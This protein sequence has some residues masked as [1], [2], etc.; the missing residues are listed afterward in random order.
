MLDELGSTVRRHFGVGLI[1]HQNNRGDAAGSDAAYDLEGEFSVLGRLSFGG[2]AQVPLY[3]FGDLASSLDMAGRTAADRDNVLAPRFEVE[4]RVESNNSVEAAGGDVQ[5]AGKVRD[6]FFRNIPK[7]VL[8]L[9]EQEYDLPVV[10]PVP[11]Y[12]ILSCLNHKR[13]LWAHYYS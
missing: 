6:R 12:D 1:V 9:L 13:T 2:K 7:G 5:F 10:F 11:C 8:G 4:L 3:P